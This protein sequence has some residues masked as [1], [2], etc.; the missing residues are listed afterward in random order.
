MVRSGNNDE[1]K[2]R[3]KRQVLENQLKRLQEEEKETSHVE[4]L[5]EHDSTPRPTEEP[6]I[7]DTPIAHEDVKCSQKSSK[8]P[9]VHIFY[10]PWYGNPKFNNGRYYHWDHSLLLLERPKKGEQKRYQPPED[11]PNVFY[12]QLSAYSSRDPSLIDQHFKWMRSAGIDVVVVS[13][14][15][16]DKADADGYLIPKLLDVCAQYKLKLAFHLEPYAGRTALSVRD[17]IEKIVKLYGN[18]SAFYKMKS[19]YGDK[20]LPV[21]YIYD[22][23]QVSTDEWA[24]IALVDGKKTI[25][26]TE[27]DALLIGLVLR[28]SDVQGVKSGGLDG[29]YTYFAADGFTEASSM[30]NWQRLSKICKENRLLFVPSVGPG[31]DDIRVRPWNGV[32]TRARDGGKYYVEHFEAAHTAKP[33]I[34]SITSF[35]EWHEGTQIE[36]AIPFTDKGN[37]YTYLQYEKG[38]EM[39]LQLTNEMIRKY[40]VPHD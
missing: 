5:H 17:D 27:F 39:Y 9:P 40:C 6:L 28:L 24:E 29:I 33:D 4:Q 11:L 7:L 34:V 30:Q 25:R 26:G 10:Y 22:S 38:P 37:E 12:P 20:L 1:M 36:P 23:Y 16:E 15:R 35:N 3:S 19:K 13:W 21:M 2:E 8:A 32:N 18:H 14:F 31:Y